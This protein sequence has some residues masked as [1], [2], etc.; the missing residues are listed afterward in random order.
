MYKKAVLINIKE[1]DLDEPFWGKLDELVGSRVF[2]T[3]DD[4]K[5]KDELK[6]CDCLL[7]GFQVDTQQDIIDAAPNL[8]YIGVLATAYGTID[9]EYAASKN[10]PVCNL[11]GYSSEAVAEFT[12]AI[13]LWQIR[14]LE[15]GL[16][17][18]KNGN[19]SFDGMTARELMGSQFGV[20]GLGD[21]GNRVAE[22]AAGFGA[23]V[24][25][26]SR[27]KK[28]VPFEY[29]EVNALL[30]SCDYISVNVAE[31]P[32]TTGLINAANLASVKPGAV[33]VSTVPPAVI[34]TQALADRL[35]KNDIMFISDH[36]DEMSED[37]LAKL[38]QYKNCVLLPAI[39]FITDEA[40]QV[41]QEMFIGNIKAA[42]DKAPDNQVN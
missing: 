12:I 11:A 5:L 26:W 25:Y 39:A 14:S 31:T 38:K 35:S 42:L 18:G 41:K 17:R 16:E 1:T 21:I 22:L 29:K 32:E 34:E 28:N 30:S 13:L 15:E 40:R 8:A 7:L 3:R 36:A 27:N 20:I 4:P 24:S 2:I 9:T 33:I 37:E 19:Y 10:I 6:D 23:N